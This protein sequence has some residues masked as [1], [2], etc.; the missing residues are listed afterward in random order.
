M[1][2]DCKYIL[3]TFSVLLNKFIKMFIDF[4][5][6]NGDPGNNSGLPTLA[7]SFGELGEN[8]LF[9]RSVY[10]ACVCHGPV[11]VVK[12]KCAVER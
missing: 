10:N 12:N 9:V 11:P 6:H 3:V 1:T 2:N 7:N 5:K 8:I 4:S